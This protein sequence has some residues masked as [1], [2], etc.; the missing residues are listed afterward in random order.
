MF[1]FVTIFVITHELHMHYAHIACSHPRRLQAIP[2]CNA[3]PVCIPCMHAQNVRRLVVRH[4][5]VIRQALLSLLEAE[6]KYGYQLKSE[7]EAATGTAWLL[8]IGQVYNT[9]SRMERDGAIAGIGDDDEG[10]PLYEITANGETELATWMTATVARSTSTR[11]EVTMKVLMAAA[12]GAADPA[13]VI[14]TQRQ[15]SMDLLQQT[16]ATRA[17]ATSMADRLHLERLIVLTNAEL[18]WLDLAEQTLAEEVLA[19]DVEPS[20]PNS[21]QTTAQNSRAQKAKARGAQS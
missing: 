19:D 21:Q 8:N 11:D 4:I 6:P 2:S 13:G 17:A 1:I 7:F 20:K 15:A 3:F 5:P 9:L 14:A 12:T 18:R 16:T 10:R